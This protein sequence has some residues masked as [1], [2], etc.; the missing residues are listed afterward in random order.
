[1]KKLV[2]FMMCVSFMFSLDLTFKNVSLNE[3]KLYGMSER[4]V[5]KNKKQRDEKIAKVWEKFLSSESFS[6]HRKS[7]KYF[8]CI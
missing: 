6:K 5:Y 2:L 7:R 3:F 8:C 4:I 1:M